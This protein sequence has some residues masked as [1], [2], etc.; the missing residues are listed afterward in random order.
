MTWTTRIFVSLLAIF[1]LAS[2]I[3]AQSLAAQL[4]SGRSRRANNAQTLDQVLADDATL[5]DVTFVDAQHGWAVGDRGVI[6]STDDGGAHWTAQRS[7]VTCPL[8]SVSFADDQRGWIVGG[9]AAPL[10]HRTTGVVL[11]TMDGGAHW[12][13]VDTPTLP[14]L[15]FVKFFDAAHGVAT[16]YG[17]SFYPAGM[18]AT[19][20]GGKSWQALASR[21][22]STWLA[23]DFVDADT[24][25]LAGAHG[26]RGVVFDREIHAPPLGSTDLREPRALCAVSTTEAWLVGSDGQVLH[27]TDSGTTWQ[28]PTSPPLSLSVAMERGWQWNAVAAVGSHVWIAGM[29]GSVIAYS[30]DAGASWTPQATGLS[31][32]IEQLAFVDT[33]RGW[34]VGAAGTIVATD[35]GGRTWRR[36]RGGGRAAMLTV[37][38]ASQQMPLEATAR[39]AAGD[40]YRTAIVPLFGSTP[41]ADTTIDKHRTAEALVACGGEAQPPLWSD[42]L[43]ALAYHASPEQLLAELNRMSDGQATERLVAKMVLAI[44]GWRPEVILVSHNRNAA[45]SAADR[46]VEALLEQAIVRAADP[47]QEVNLAG[48]GVGAWQVKRTVGLLPAG[49]RG[50][51]RMATD[52][53]VPALGG[54]PSHQASTARGLLFSEHTIPAPLVEMEIIKQL[55]GLATSTRDPFA[56]LNLPSGGDARR[57]VIMSNPS[58]LDRLRKLTQ[59][60]GQLVRLLEYTEGSPIWSGQVV[61]LT[62]G[63]DTESGGELLYQLAE[64]YRSTGRQAMAAD[65]LYLLARRY[66]DHPLTEQALGWLVQYYA[67]GEIAHLT[68]RRQAKEIRER[69]LANVDRSQPGT[70]P[71]A[72]LPQDQGGGTNDLDADGRLERATALGDYLSSN[73]P[74]MYAEPALRFPLAVASRKLGFDNTAD[75]YFMVLAKQDVAAG[76]STAAQAET[77]LA[78]PDE[79]PPNK[80]VATC[81]AIAE[82]PHLD[83]QFDEPFWQQARAF[84]VETQAGRDDLTAASVQLARDENFLYIAIRAP[85]MAGETYPEENG[86]RA[87]DADLSAFDRVKLSFD[88]DRDYSSAYELTVDCRGWTSDACWGDRSWNPK[89]YVAQRLTPQEWSVE[90]AVPWSEMSEEGPALLDAW[91]LRATRETSHGHAA[92]WTG[93]ADHSPDAFGLLLFR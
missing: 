50:T 61:Q 28:P 51:I 65:T 77:W 30:A 33:Q 12:Q 81:K 45:G 7:G 56:G 26:A 41:T 23:A 62:A 19:R 35:D 53:F 14:R 66:P 74:A 64:G 78:K 60:R 32:P 90:I 34:A 29:P 1:T 31:L 80:P 85:R 11:R 75:R 83:G 92:S 6:L 5:H 93:T 40:G 46:L 36:Q 52:D 15:T 47:T 24:G 58:D 71:P 18:F 88:I 59:K 8:L 68:V 55:A 48:L 79:L 43:P 3:Y 87:R 10:T 42:D 2:P 69:P 72:E 13:T 37:V 49:E 70:P 54:S 17:S 84:R 67:S 39:Y 4:Q 38:G 82:P 76:W 63:L 25:Y 57:P 21:S 86:P 16:G 89:W 44:R 20:D 91:C 9:S 73:R 22:Q 27:S